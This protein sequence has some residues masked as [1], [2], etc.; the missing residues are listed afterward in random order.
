MGEGVY[1]V[2]ATLYDTI[3][4]YSEGECLLLEPLPN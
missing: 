1:V 2:R 4:V 3:P